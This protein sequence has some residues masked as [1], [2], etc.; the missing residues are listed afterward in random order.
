MHKIMSVAERR[1][2]EREELRQKILDQA[3]ELF[4]AHGYEGV[5]LRK[6]ANAIEYAP[7]TIYSYFKDK[8][9]LLRALCVA[10][11][12]SFEQ[13]FPRSF[14]PSKPLD[15][16]R[17]IGAAY[18]RFALENPNQYRLMFMTPKPPVMKELDDELLAKKGD[19]AR[20][21]YALLR[22]VVQMAIDAN[23]LCE[24]FR[25]AEVVAQTVWAGVHGMASLEI[26]MGGDPWLEWTP[27]EERINAI[28]DVLLR[29][30]VADDAERA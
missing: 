17:G 29:G 9:E 20:D 18:V 22:Q 25:D 10:D 7:G 19:P 30:L 5:T 21:G 3:R 6:I 13:N 4:I 27:R 2:R 8:D 16:L 28:L 1:A 26:A 14:E 23:L 11:W 12:E 15:A 24:H